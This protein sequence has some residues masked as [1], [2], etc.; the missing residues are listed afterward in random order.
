MRLAKAIVGSLMHA[1]RLEGK[2]L[3]N[4]WITTQLCP[5]FLRSLE[6]ALTQQLVLT[7]AG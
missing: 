7:C 4:I 1:F 3:E 2:R 6:P 5:Y